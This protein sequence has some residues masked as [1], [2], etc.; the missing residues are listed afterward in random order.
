VFRGDL[1]KD[2]ELPGEGESAAGTPPH[3]RRTH[4]ARRDSRALHRAGDLHAAGIDPAPRRPGPGW[5][6]FPHARAAGTVAADFPHVNTVLLRRLYVLVLIEHGTRR[7]HTGGVTA[8][9]AGAWTVQ[10][11]RNLAPSP[12]ERFEGVKFLIR[13]RG[14]DF[15]ASFDA[16]CQ[17]A[18]TKIPRT[19]AQPPRMNAICE[20]LAGTLRRKL[21]D[22]ALIPGEAHLRTVPAECQAHY[23]TARPHQDIAQRVPDGEYPAPLATATDSGIEPNRRKPVLNGLTNEYMHAA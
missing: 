21:P 13:D 17:A 19:A 16:V 23:N 8:S 12:G 7:M 11:A 10:Q 5:R 14:P 15:T 2:A 4:Q 20:R 9:P 18:G 1:A 22:R 3:P 6:Q